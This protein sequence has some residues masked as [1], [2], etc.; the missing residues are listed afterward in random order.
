MK[1]RFLNVSVAKVIK[2]LPYG[3][4]LGLLM[5]WVLAFYWWAPLV[6]ILF[7]TMVLF[8]ISMGSITIFKDSDKE[9]IKV[10][11]MFSNETFQGPFSIENWWNYDF[12]QANLNLAYNESV[13]E[14]TS[15]EIRVFTRIS[16]K[17]NKSILF[18]EA[19]IF[20]TRFP[21]DVKYDTEKEVKVL[22]VLFIQRSDK[23]TQF[24][25]ENLTYLKI[26]S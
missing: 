15:G 10:T 21:N 1:F 9:F 14:N 8:I 6:V 4:M 3:L 19:I 13:V 12:K 5:A 22:D 18:K 17:Y 2:Y 23:L 7:L 16:D 24:L 25:S 11:T 26:I 20:G